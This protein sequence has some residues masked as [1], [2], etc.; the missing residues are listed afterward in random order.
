MGKEGSSVINLL[1]MGVCAGTARGRLHCY[2]RVGAAAAK[3]IGADPEWEKS[4]L[5]E[6][7]AKAKAQLEALAERC[8]REGSSCC[9]NS[10]RISSTS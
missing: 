8:R 3:R 6:A 2:H 1:G 10:R 5:T 7:Q 4:R 9:R